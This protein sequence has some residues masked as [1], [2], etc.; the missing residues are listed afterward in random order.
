MLGEDL[1]VTQ[2]LW[3]QGRN[4]IEAPLFN[5]GPI[6]DESWTYVFHTRTI[7]SYNYG[8]SLTKLRVIKPIVAVHDRRA[9]ELHLAHE[10]HREA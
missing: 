7:F 10:K 3:R 5:N 8:E 2:P 6:A 9:G 4:G 1:V